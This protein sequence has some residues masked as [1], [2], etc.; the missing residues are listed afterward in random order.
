MRKLNLNFL[1]AKIFN[2]AFSLTSTLEISKGTQNGQKRSVSL[3]SDNI[4]LKWSQTE[5]LLFLVP[6][7]KS[8]C[9]KC[10]EYTRKSTRFPYPLSDDYT[11]G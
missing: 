9:L 3:V 4:L 6:F 11:R 2:K 7:K 1:L 10:P 5:A 8:P